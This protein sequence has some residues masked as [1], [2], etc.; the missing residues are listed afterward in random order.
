ML[1]QDTQNSKIAVLPGKTYLVHLINIGSFIGTY[2]TMDGHTMTI[3]EVDGVYT[4]AQDVNEVYLSVAQRYSVLITT[5]KDASKN[6]AISAT[7]DTDMFDHPE[8]Y[9]N[10]DVFG[11]L[12][13]D[14]KKP[15]PTPTPIRT[16]DVFDDFQLIPKDRQLAYTNVDHQIMIDMTLGPDEGVNR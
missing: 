13:Y 10:P 9:N 7:L 3:V 2:I 11:Y 1:M 4:H 8:A 6:F 12:V 14:S 5:K 16:Y 15:L